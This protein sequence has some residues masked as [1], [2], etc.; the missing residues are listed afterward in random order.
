M[1][2]Y[3]A[4]CQRKE[5]NFRRNSSAKQRFTIPESSITLPESA[6]NFRDEFAVDSP[7]QRGVTCEPD[8]VLVIGT[9]G[10]FASS[11]RLR[12]SLERIGDRLEARHLGP[13]PADAGKQAQQQ[14]LR[15][16]SR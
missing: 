8:L 6:P 14:R 5:D 7:L 10:I 15:R 13:R 16:P 1:S 2:E 11:A 9:V 3:G 4:G 12:R